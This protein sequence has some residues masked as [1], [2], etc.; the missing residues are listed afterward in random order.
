MKITEPIIGNETV[1]SYLDRLK[2]I[3]EISPT[4]EGAMYLIR[5]EF[6]KKDKEI[7]KKANTKK[8]K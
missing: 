1:A 8:T 4:Y 7:K 2:M 6:D 5:A 3:V